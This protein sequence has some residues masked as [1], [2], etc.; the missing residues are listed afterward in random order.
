MNKTQLILMSAIVAGAQTA[1]AD[2]PGW[3]SSFNL[4]LAIPDG[5]LT[6][7]GDDSNRGP[8][9]DL[10]DGGVAGV[11]GGYG[12][13]NG[14][15]LGAELRYRAFDAGGISQAAFG[16]P[17]LADGSVASTTLMTNLSYDFILRG[18]KLR[19][20]V[21]GGIGAAWN[22]ANADVFGPDRSPGWGIY[23]SATDTQFAW[24]LGAGVAY[25]I[26][27]SLSL[28]AEYQYVDLGNAETGRDINGQSM[29]FDDL[30]SNEVTLGLRYRF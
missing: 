15:R 29:R 16:A 7:S 23:S 25:P 22:E 3:Y 19:P 6:H 21:K 24:S 5:S 27:D 12:F 9:F 11:G 8:D 26:D 18:S 2:E 1:N 10:D 17:S 20:Y 28:T 30:G 14:L 13:G 4:G